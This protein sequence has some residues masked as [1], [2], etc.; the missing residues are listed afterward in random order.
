MLRI[1]AGIIHGRDTWLTEVVE[2]LV[3]QVD[4]IFIWNNRPAFSF[5]SEKIHN[6]GT[7]NNY[8]CARGCYEL[9]RIADDQGFDAIVLANDDVVC[10]PGYVEASSAILKQMPRVAYVSTPLTNCGPFPMLDE[11]GDGV[12][13]FQ[14]CV[15]GRV[16]ELMSVAPLI[17]LQAAREIGH[18]PT[19]FF[20]HSHETHFCWDLWRHNWQVWQLK[21]EYLHHYGGHQGKDILGPDRE[22]IL[23]QDTWRLYWWWKQLP[24]AEWKRIKEV[25]PFLYKYVFVKHHLCSHYGIRPE[26]A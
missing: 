26:E 3:G 19:W 16:L 18:W 5:S 24:L 1:A 8:G 25:A 4:R 10:F 9:M 17:R 22:A 14:G 21:D 6:L 15:E 2:S 12:V 20:Q 7:A 11:K 23:Q 13:A